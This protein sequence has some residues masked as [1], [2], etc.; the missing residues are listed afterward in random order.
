MGIK[1]RVIRKEK[2]MH[3][4]FHVFSSKFEKIVIECEY[5]DYM[6][7]FKIHLNMWLEICKNNDYKG[8]YATGFVKKFAP[9]DSICKYLESKR[10]ERK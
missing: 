6:E 3:Y 10:N 5:E 9:D 8:R 4:L 2:K 7:V 1:R